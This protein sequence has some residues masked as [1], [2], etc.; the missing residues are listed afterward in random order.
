ML[1]EKKTLI[2]LLLIP[3][4]L[5]VKLLANFPEFVEQYYSNGV[6][7]VISRIFRFTLGWIPFSFGDL[8]Y[9][10]VLVYAVRWLF[11]NR[12]R[13]RKDTKRWLVDVMAAFSFFYGAFH[14]FWGLNYYR[15]PLHNSLNL[16]HDYTT[17]QLTSVTKAL[18]KKSNT[19]HLEIT[20]ND[21]VKVDM[22]FG[23]REIF[24]MVPTAYDN[25]KSRFPHLEYRPRSLK[26]SIYSY[27]LTYMGFSGYLN[28]FTNEAQV[29][30]LIPVYKFPTTSAHEI[31]HQLGYAAENEA[32]FIGFMAITSHDNIYFKYTGYTFALRFCLNEIYRRDEALY[33]A[34]VAHVN[35]GILKNY[36]EVR[37]FWSVHENPMEPFFKLFYGNFLK[38]NSQSKGMQ[39]YNYVVA[40]LVNYFEASNDL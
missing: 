39:S 12:R 13:L 18:I 38:A 35:P 8:I 9:T 28:P 25:L 11:K 26:Q 20:K 1:K 21:S 15:L 2:A 40:L 17:G 37:D 5:L 6:Y 14:L 29:D 36:K 34:V 7:P 19:L 31:A 33:K 23:K 30:G 10:I 16:A 27:P 3:Q 4:F 22:P 24:K 32:N